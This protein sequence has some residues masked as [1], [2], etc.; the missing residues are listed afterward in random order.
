MKF[1]KYRVFVEFHP[2]Y[3]FMWMTMRLP[4][5]SFRDVGTQFGIEMVRVIR[6]IRFRGPITIV[7]QEN[8]V[9]K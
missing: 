9:E 8:E 4:V 7:H 2:I 3:W 5:A 6:V 1:G